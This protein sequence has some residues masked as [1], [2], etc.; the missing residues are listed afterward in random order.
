MCFFIQ[1]SQF[2]SILDSPELQKNIS[3]LDSIIGQS[4][5]FA[6]SFSRIG[7]DFRGLLASKFIKIIEQSFEL[8]ISK[9]NKK[10]KQEMDKFAIHK[11]STVG[12][13]KPNL[14]TKPE[15]PPLCLIEFYPLVDYLNEILT[16]FNELRSCA[17]LSTADFIANLIQESLKFCSKVIL[18]YYKIEQ[19][20]FEKTE[21]EKFARFCG[22]FQMLVNYLQKCIHLVFPLQEVANHMGIPIHQ[23]Q[24]EGVT[25]INESAILEPINHLLPVEIHSEIIT[26]GA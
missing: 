21:K 1:I 13:I 7:A 11:I 16:A 12:K 8:S 4:M 20:T 9:I 5:Y 3:S 14:E 24:K 25:F 2:L 23:L 10:F 19:Q 15:Q 6:H 18:S 17:L 22:G 26:E